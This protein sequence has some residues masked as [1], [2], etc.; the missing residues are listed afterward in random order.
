M[1]M[2][3]VLFV[4]DDNYILKAIKRSLKNIVI[5]A[6]YCNHAEEAL[7]IMSENEIAMIVADISMPG[8]DGVTL[9]KKVSELYPKTIRVA[10]TG[11]NDF[12]EVYG[13]LEEVALFKYITKPWENNT[14]IDLV[15]EGVHA[16][17][18]NR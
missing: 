15:E 2:R 8:M 9:L 13:I 5:D 10:L 3:E 6:C 12:N 11:T 4:D 1:S 14:L 18:V 7:K 17:M 16:Y